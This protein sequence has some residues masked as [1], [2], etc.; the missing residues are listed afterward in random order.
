M[1]DLTHNGVCRYPS[2][3]LSLSWGPGSTEGVLGLEMANDGLGGGAAFHLAADRSGDRWTWPEIQTLN[4][5][6]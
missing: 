5:C 3:Y 4:L 6:E 1:V 2:Y